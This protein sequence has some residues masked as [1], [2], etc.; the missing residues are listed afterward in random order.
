MGLDGCRPTKPVNRQIKRGQVNR[1]V[2]GVDLEFDLLACTKLPFA[3]QEILSQNAMIVGK[4]RQWTSQGA[5][6]SVL[7]P[8]LLRA[9]GAARCGIN[10]AHA[11]ALSR[12]R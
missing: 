7:L 10:R 8:K 12:Q 2:A 11:A 1:D 3:S 6:V 5:K 9:V 4:G